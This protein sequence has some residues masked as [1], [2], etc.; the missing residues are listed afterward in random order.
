M[1]QIALC[2]SG[3]RQFND[4][5]SVLRGGYNPQDVGIFQINEHYHLQRSKD[6][7]LDIYTLEGNIGYALLLYQENGTRDW[8]W[9]KSCWGS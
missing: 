6:L 9:S 7:G 1:Q 3:K 8:N 5:G 4:D 2:E